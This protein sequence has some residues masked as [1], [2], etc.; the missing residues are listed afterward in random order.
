MV[1]IGDNLLGL[2]RQYEICNERFYDNFS[3]SIELDKKYLKP[4]SFE[5]TGTIRYDLQ[6][7]DEYFEQQEMTS[8]HLVL[9][10]GDAILGCSTVAIKMPLGYMGWVQTKGS[11]ARLF[12][13]ST[14]NDSQI[15]PGYNGRI[16]LEIINY[17]PFNIELSYRSKVAQM[18]ILK[19]STSNSTP[20]SGRYQN[21][22]NPTIA[23]L[24]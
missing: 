15:E 17:S 2:I 19:C 4:K 10:P 16:T 14:C 1:I 12:V 3:I 24:P 8:G 13:A 5:K 18:Y 22:L 20:Y 21:A 11:L 23:Q 6:N 7:V 9:K